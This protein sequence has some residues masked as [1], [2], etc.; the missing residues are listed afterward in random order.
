MEVIQLHITGS[1][2]LD[3]PQIVLKLKQ[4]DV[5]IDLNIHSIPAEDRELLSKGN[6]TA[7]DVV[8]EHIPVHHYFLEFL[9]KHG[10][11]ESQIE[12]NFWYLNLDSIDDADVF[13][14]NS[15]VMQVLVENYLRI[16]K[17]MKPI[18]YPITMQDIL[19]FFRTKTCAEQNQQHTPP[20]NENTV[21]SK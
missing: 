13:Y 11:H 2:V 21:P 4:A 19:N 9:R 18:G 20:T 7:Y 3:L 1:L 12:E 10:R 16:L 14:A 5:C 17:S 8:F 15:L 6:P